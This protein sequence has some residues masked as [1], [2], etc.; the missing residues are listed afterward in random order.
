MTPDFSSVVN[1]NLIEDDHSSFG[2]IWRKAPDSAQGDACNYGANFRLGT[3]EA[4]SKSQ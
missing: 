2:S 1:L 4:S 3:I